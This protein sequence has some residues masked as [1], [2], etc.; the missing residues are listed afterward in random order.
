MFARK[1]TQATD[2]AALSRGGDPLVGLRQLLLTGVPCL[3]HEA[4][5]R[6]RPIRMMVSPMWH[7]LLVMDTRKGGAVGKL[8]RKQCKVER[9][10][11]IE[12]GPDEG[13]LSFHVVFSS[14]SRWTFFCES[15]AECKVRGRCAPLLRLPRAKSSPCAPATS[16]V[17]CDPVYPS[18]F[19]SLRLRASNS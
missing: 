11:R 4:K 16:T 2:E 19:A 15:A 14:A 10:H 3:E 13:R 17:P 18:L 1:C 8:P 5:G 9:V 7:Y 12:L 6:P